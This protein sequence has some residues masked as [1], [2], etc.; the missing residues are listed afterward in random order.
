MGNSKPLTEDS[1]MIAFLDKAYLPIQVARK[2]HTNN[3]K[4]V[5]FLLIS[6]PKKGFVKRLDQNRFKKIDPTRRMT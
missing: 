6:P 5:K 2:A 4:Q 3:V 1:I